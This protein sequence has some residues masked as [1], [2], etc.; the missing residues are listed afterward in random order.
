YWQNLSDG[1]ESIRFFSDEEL[2]DAGID[3]AVLSDP[4]YVKANGVLEGIELFDATFFGISPREAEISDPQ[5]RLFLECAWAALE[6]AAYDPQR[7]EGAI[8]VFAGAG[9]NTY[10]MNLIGNRDVIA[11]A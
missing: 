3:M 2:A 9:L 4:A 10:W 8:A 1:V 11:A 7:Y 5:Q 6:D